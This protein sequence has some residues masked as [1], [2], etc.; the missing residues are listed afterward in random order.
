[1]STK[2]FAVEVQVGNE[3]YIFNGTVKGKVVA[4][5]DVGLVVSRTAD[6]QFCSWL[7]REDA[8]ALAKK[9]GKPLKDAARAAAVDAP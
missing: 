9:L 4:F 7:S 8:L 3:S 2:V 6:D 1:M 5:E